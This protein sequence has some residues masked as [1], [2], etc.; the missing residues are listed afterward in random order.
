MALLHKVVQYKNHIIREDLICII[1]FKVE[2][3]VM[4]INTTEDITKESNP[5]RF[6]GKEDLI[7]NIKIFVFIALVAGLV[8][9]LKVSHDAS[10]SIH[11]NSDKYC[12]HLMAS[13]PDP[14]LDKHDECIMR[15]KHYKKS[16]KEIFNSDNEFNWPLV[17]NYA[18]ELDFPSY[19]KVYNFINYDGH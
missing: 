19:E 8:T 17:R 12:A 2:F 7:L 9:L 3:E 16:L 13:L 10:L 11:I 18:N 15:E 5:H 1:Y 14:T 6:D 4:H